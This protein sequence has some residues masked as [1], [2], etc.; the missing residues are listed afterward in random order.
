MSRAGLR[1]VLALTV[2]APLIGAA[3][4]RP[5]HAAG[6]GG[7]TEAEVLRLGER[8]YRR[9]I[10]PSGEPMTGVVQGDVPVDGTMFSCQSCHLRSGVGSIEGTVITL[11]TNAG[12]LFQPFRGARMTETARARL[13]AH[14]RREQIRPAYTVESLAR[15]LRTGVDPA[16]RTLGPQMPRYALDDD[17]M[18]V[19]VHYLEHL[20]AAP[21]P[22]VTDDTIRFATV[23]GAGASATERSAMLLPLRAHV[24]A[25]NT[26]T[27][28]QER[29]AASGPFY[30]EEKYTAYRRLEL[31]VW[32]LRGPPETWRSQ[33]E[34]YYRDR[35]VFALLGGVTGGPWWPIHAFCEANRIPALFPIT[36]LPVVSASDWYTL[37]FSK[38]RFQEG[39]AVARYLR[40]RPDPGS[41][42]AA[43]RPVVQVYR[44]DPEGRALAEG[45][46]ATWAAFGRPA[47]VE[48]VLGVEDAPDAGF[49]R[50]LADTHPRAVLLLWLRGRDL[51]GLEAIADRDEA[52]PPRV[53]LSGPL[54][55]DDRSAVPD[56]VRRFTLLTHPFSL[57]GEKPR[58]ELVTRRWLESRG[59]PV[60]D[61][62]IQSQMYLLG[63][64]L[65]GVIKKM[66]HDLYRDYF[67]DVM[68][69]MR[70]QYYSVAAYPRL[71]FG[72]GQRYAS[73]GCYLVELGPGPKPELIRRAG[74]VIQ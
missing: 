58:A 3:A 7:R 23:V 26:Q 35:P 29:R 19:L 52:G 2:L 30:K 22:G 72:P 70:D 54:L 47:P 36:D 39:E 18:A 24:A 32:E 33:L 4:Q 37:Y 49:W 50:R 61:A 5:A 21:S 45:F 8:M 17:D 48:R 28:Q 20:S 53:F 68:D 9:G 40:S 64:M 73:K 46:R 59:I 44:D 56:A 65:S 67:L 13:P 62:R 38:G 60:A 12:W 43:G 55:G 63:W 34:A 51:P 71:S 14:L 25:A 11:P 6:A 57:P 16:G 69:M 10:L 42:P 15:V 27:R 41:G 31:S 1:G 74:W 66:R